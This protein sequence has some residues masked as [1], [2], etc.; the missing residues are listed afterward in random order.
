MDQCFKGQIALGYKHF[1]VIS[2]KSY[3]FLAN[4]SLQNNSWLFSKQGL[5]YSSEVCICSFTCFSYMLCVL[6][7]RL[8][9]TCLVDFLA[10]ALRF[11]PF[12][13]LKVII[14]YIVF[15]LNHYRQLDNCAMHG[16]HLQEETATKTPVGGRL[17]T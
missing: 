6:F 2:L 17:N 5:S 9:A 11:S 14:F 15:L 10:L 1:I 8:T 16:C 12:E 3:F 4:F 13:L 7:L